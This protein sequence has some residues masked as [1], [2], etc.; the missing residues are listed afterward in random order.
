MVFRLSKSL[1]PLCVPRAELFT[2]ELC[3]MNINI[4]LLWWT[5]LEYTGHCVCVYVWLCRCNVSC[6][7][8]CASA[9]KWHWGLNAAWILSRNVCVCVCVC[10]LLCVKDRKEGKESEKN[11]ATSPTWVSI[12][13]SCRRSSLLSEP[14]VLCSNTR[15]KCSMH[16]IDSFSCRVRITS[17]K[18]NRKT[19]NNRF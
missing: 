11:K 3:D 8:S 19:H 16:L 4:V 9:D 10:Q 1:Q 14:S 2:S 5:L 6:R 7:H 17:W 15:E 13:C 18:N 12:S